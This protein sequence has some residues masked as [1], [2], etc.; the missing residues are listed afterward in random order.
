MSYLFAHHF[1]HNVEHASRC[2][3]HEAAMFLGSE[4][5]EQT[6]QKDEFARLFNQQPVR[7]VAHVE[8]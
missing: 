3:E 5:V 6:D 8:E 2:G 4:V 7:D 1:L